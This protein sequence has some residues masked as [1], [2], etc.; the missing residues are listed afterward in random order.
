MRRKAILVVGPPRSG[1]SVVSHVLSKLGVDFGDHSRFVDPEINTYNPLFFELLLLNK[2]NDEVFGCFSK[3]LADFDWMPERA[4]FDERL[5]SLF[6]EKISMFIENEFSDSKIIGLKDTRFCYTLPLWDTILKN[7]GFHVSY[8]FVRR[9][10]DSVF[11]S[12]KAIN[13]YSSAVNFRLVAQSSL[14]AR[15][16]LEGS[17]YVTVHYEDLIGDP[18]S[19]IGHMCKGFNL[20][21]SLM[22][23]ARAVIRNDLTHQKRT[24]NKSRYNYFKNVINSTSISP[25]EHLLYR[26]IYSAAIFDK[27]RSMVTLNQAVEERD[28]HIAALNS[29]L[30]N[31]DVIKE[32]EY[33][34]TL[35]PVLLQQTEQL[36]AL[37][38]EV[39]SMRKHFFA[40]N[41]ILSNDDVIKEENNSGNQE[42]TLHLQTEQL[43]AVREM[44]TALNNI[45]Q[46]NGWKALTFCYKIRD[47]LMSFA[48][49]QKNLFK[50]GMNIFHSVL[51]SLPAT[52]QNEGGVRPLISKAVS[53]LQQEG[54]SGLK[55][56][57]F[58]FKQRVGKK[59]SEAYQSYIK[60]ME[61]TQAD[62]DRT[63][64][65]LTVLT[66]RPKFSIVV[67]VYNVEEK[68]LRMF[69]ESVQKQIYP[70]WEL[71]IA[72]DCSTI[73]QVRSTLLKYAESDQ[74]IKVVFREE[75]GH[76]SAATNSALELATG[77]FMSLMDN[78]DAIAPN[79]LYEFA[80][81]LNQDPQ[82]DMIYSDE[83]K[84]D[85][86]GNRY[87]PFF[88]PDWSP[89]T[90]EGCMYTAHFACYRMSIVRELKGFRLGFEGAQDY[91]FALRFTERAEKIVHTPKI[92][93]HWRSIPGS[94]ASTMDSK[95][96]VIDSAVRALTD[97][98]IRVGGGG[99]VSLGDYP[100]SFDVRYSIKNSPLVSIIIASAGRNAMLRG[101]SINLLVNVIKSIHEN[102]TYSNFEIIV[103]DNCDLSEETTNSLAAYNCKFVHFSGSFNIAEKMNM[104]AKEARGEYLLF[105]N[106]D[107]EVIKRDWMECMLQLAQRPGIGAVGAK[108]FFENNKIQHA[109][110]AFW[111]GLPDHILRESP[112]EYPGH[113]FSSCSNR[114]YLAVT[115]AVMMTSARVF[116]EVEG[117]D[118]RFAVNY[119][120]IDYCLKVFQTGQRIVFASGTELY[121]YESVS[122]ERVVAEEEISLF[123]SKWREV[124]TKDPYYGPYFDNHP[125]NFLL[126]NDWRSVKCVE[127]LKS[128]SLSHKTEQCKEHFTSEQAG[129]RG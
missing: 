14:L 73:P 93:Y 32:Q 78:D 114:N 117:F 105:M 4:D 116:K 5:V 102:T 39:D 25:D 94:T 60:I 10:P 58:Q 69:I 127:P 18:E 37:R 48:L 29:I 95:N 61:P 35:D 68:W 31:N 96:Y 34:R 108:L 16:F 15:H 3:K 110:I 90:L 26:E 50:N 23:E 46:S 30:S 115:G 47:S 38:G 20:N 63:K 74:R 124:V 64:E 53:V 70:D 92:L 17:H 66:Y 67:P 36:S 19:T 59:H 123:Q 100:G 45:Y 87:E 52:V 83:D 122:R 97:R 33:R 104:G 8:A 80:V 125:P 128:L 42:P 21:P 55:G 28:N 49:H 86:N 119:N 57:L 77:D 24:S 112:R 40:L 103:V 98:A 2:L 99:M 72:D 91:D 54:L 62:L 120:D 71:C 111:N 84:I 129:N 27:D 65:N 7:L 9:F 107:I 12:N 75:N 41:S 22:N 118:E 85:L 51:V 43:S 82:I 88:K 121:H 109:G 79:A 106:D 89:E 76:I 101:M 126:R 81:L 6:K 56:R 1:T 11:D 44:H 13:K 113:F